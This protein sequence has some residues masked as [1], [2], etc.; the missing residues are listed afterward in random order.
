[1]KMQ[2][3]EKQLVIELLKLIKLKHNSIKIY[4]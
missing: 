3:I 2:F 1:M 4:S